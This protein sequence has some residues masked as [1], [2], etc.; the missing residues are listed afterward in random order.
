MSEYHLTV[1]LR[2]TVDALNVKE[3]G[4]Y[5]DC[6]GGGGGHSAEILSRLGRGGRLIVLDRDPDA[7]A[8]LKERFAGDERVTVVHSEFSALRQV[9]DSL[10]VD[11]V[12]G[13]VADLGV[14]SHQLDDPA[15][16][17][18]YRYDAPLDMRMDP[19]SGITAAQLIE[20][21]DEREIT[22][23]LYQ[24]GEERYARSI[25]RAIVRAREKKSIETTFELSEIVKSAV[26]AAVR[27]AGQPARKTFQALRIALNHELDTLE[28]SINTMFDCL[29][30]SGRIAIITF[31]SL[32]DKIA[33]H[34]I[35]EF[36]R[37]CDCDPAAPVC[38]C[39]KKPRAR[40][41]FRSVTPGE[42]E[43]EN[44]SRARS[45]RLRAAEKIRMSVFDD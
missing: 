18:S 13:V 20:T 45:A 22:R 32:E 14:S 43:L 7:V 15:R 23:I 11:L 8:V 9:L 31:H 37:G 44:N 10:G 28:E 30:V 16:G 4:T 5:V 38:T 29:A 27:R 34:C 12:D 21:L 39:G 3:N 2:E 19:G 40:T 17:F 35:T 24:Y 26:P 42:E 36:C 1:L 25:A 33:K 41:V 6:T